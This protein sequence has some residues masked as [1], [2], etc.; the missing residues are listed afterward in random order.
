MWTTY[1]RQEKRLNSFHLRSICRILGISW[2]KQR[3]CPDSTFQACPSYLDSTSCVGWVMSTAWRMTASQKTYFMESWHVG[4]ELK[5][6]HSC[7]TRM[8]AREHSISALNPGRTLQ[9]TAWGG[10]ALWTN[11]LSQTKRSFWMQKLEKGPTERSATTPTDQR[12]HTNVTFVAE[13]VSATVVSTA[14]NNAATNRQD[15]QNVLPWSN[16]IDRGH[17]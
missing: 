6:A 7:P 5:A 9:L 10:E 15:N 2:K 17:I 3:S 12:P 4:G 13:I 11:T 8:S 16:L 14:T 1:A